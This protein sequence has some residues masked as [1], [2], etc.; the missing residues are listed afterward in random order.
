MKAISESLGKL[1]L[2]SIVL[3][4]FIV[5][6]S[7][8]PFAHALVSSHLKHLYQGSAAVLFIVEVA[9]LGLTISAFKTRISFLYQGILFPEFVA[10]RL[11][12]RHQERMNRLRRRYF[13]IRGDRTVQE[14]SAIER[15]I[16]SRLTQQLLDYPSK[17][18]LDGMGFE[19]TNA[20]LLG[21]IISTARMYPLTRYGLNGE[22]YWHHFVYLA[23]EPARTGYSDAKAAADSLILASYSGLLATLVGMIFLLARSLGSVLPDLAVGP[24]VVP[25]SFGWGILF[26]GLLITLVFYWQSLPAHRAASRAFQALVDLSATSVQRWINDTDSSNRAAS[27]ENAERMRVA[28]RF[29]KAPKDS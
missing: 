13:S 23:P 28:L 6:V 21:N 24:A 29:L 7:V 5:A 18:S 8:H 10:V 25:D 3:P 17:P 11:L 4:G 22:A 1:D 16:V 12:R 14:L 27:N 26:G 15:R 19:P 2:R 20:N 9:L